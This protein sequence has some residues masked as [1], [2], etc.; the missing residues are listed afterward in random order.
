MCFFITGKQT[1]CFSCVLLSKCFNAQSQTCKINVV[2][3]K[4]LQTLRWH[5]FACVWTCRYR[6]QPHFHKNKQCQL[7]S[8]HYVYPLTTQNLIAATCKTT[9]QL[10]RKTR[11]RKLTH[12]L[13]YFLRAKRPWAKVYR[14]FLFTQEP[15]SCKALNKGG[16]HTKPLSVGSDENLTWVLICFS[17]STNYS[18]H[19]QML[20]FS[21]SVYIE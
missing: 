15:V 3:C 5:G 7:G 20:C 12:I 16:K 14:C 19:K 6:K 4:K 13:C 11:S 18:W 1:Y 17:I 21:K 10:H 9:I 2:T 8:K